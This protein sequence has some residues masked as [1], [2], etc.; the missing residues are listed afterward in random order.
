[1][2]VH[3]RIEG[4]EGLA[5]QIHR[6]IRAAII[7]GRLRA[8]EPIPSTRELATRLMV[9]RNTVV[10]AYDRLAAEGFLITR[11]RGR[12]YVLGHPG[13]RLPVPEMMERAIRP[14]PVWEHQPEPVDMAAA[15]PAYDFR[16]GLPDAS[17]FP[18]ATWRA[19][20]ADTFRRVSVGSGGYQDPAG[21]PGLRAAIARHIGVSRSIRAGPDDIL[22]TSGSQ[23][24]VDLIARVL[25]EPGQVAVVENPGW[26]P[27]R[28]LFETS[29]ARVVSAPVDREGLVVEAL[30]DRARVLYVSPSHQF[31]LGVP[32]SDRR[33]KALLEWARRT[34]AVIIEDDYDS[35]FRF[36]G[37]PV[38]PLHSLDPS[39]RVIYVGSFSK[40]LLPTLRLGFCVVPPTLYPALRRAKYVV[41]WHTASPMQAALARYLDEGR[42]A[43]HIRRMRRV[44][45]ARRDRICQRLDGD[46][47]ELLEPLPSVAG[48]HLTAWLHATQNT[49]EGSGPAA[50]QVVVERCQRAGIG[51]YPVSDFGLPGTVRPG[52]VLGY[53]A[54]DLDRID[55]GLDLLRR[56]L[57]WGGRW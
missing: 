27:P 19:L 4:P 45:Q 11:Q 13:Q 18:F 7:D 47:A 34:D 15:T 23:Q 33:R 21:H 29:G 39:A 36:G 14:R 12:T 38:D 20:L 26:P 49:A 35:E 24:A 32:L 8:G 22:I 51:L 10:V 25:L 37:R 52:L 44:Y 41:D 57:E 3:I 17:R 31:P 9:S 28:A 6:Q 55:E 40:T 16:P 1:M 50:D 48:L 30:P 53:G 54:V 42:F 43:R 2:D 46:L 5:V 56:C